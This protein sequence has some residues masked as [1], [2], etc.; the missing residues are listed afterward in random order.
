MFFAIGIARAEDN[1]SDAIDPSVHYQTVDHFTAS[2]CWSI[3][4]IGGWSDANRKK[5]AD[6]LFS[7]DKG[8]GLS[9]WRCNLG[10]GLDNAKI[11]SSW[12]RADTYEV[13][14]G[15]YDWTRC[16]NQR[17]FLAAAKARGVRE[18]IAF[19]NSPPERLT[20][21][22][23]TC[24]DANPKITNN[25]KPGMEH[26][27]G[28]YLADI[29]AHFRDNPDPAERINFTWVSPINE[30][31][32]DWIGG[33]EGSRASN[34][35]IRRQ[36]AAIFAELQRQHLSTHILGPE[37]GNIPDM[38]TR[39]GASDKYHAAFGDYVD[40]LCGDPALVSAMDHTIGY[41]SYWSDDKLHILY[42]RQV[43]RKKLDQFPQWRV[44]ETEYCVMEPGRNLGM[45]TAIRAMRIVEA[46]LT[47]ANAS[48]WA[49]WL[50][51]S[52]GDYKDGLLYTDWHRPGDEENVLTSK[53]FWAYGNFTR[54]V[55]P[56]MVRIAM[57]DT[58]AK[59]DINGLMSSAWRDPVN[60]KIVVVYIN[61]GD[62]PAVVDLKVSGG[63]S[64]KWTPF[65]TSDKPGDDLREY[66]A[67]AAGKAIHI[68]AT[69]VVTLVS[70]P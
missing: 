37:S 10:G 6:L 63:Q 8:I 70:Q 47:I 54:F 36:Y 12:R 45:A 9:A 35:D 40:T 11:R 32:W 61:A 41:H 7:R 48:G 29:L 58:A 33:Q 14:E 2:D 52:N 20:V 30:P 65:V 31:Q 13:A 53:L 43:L 1:Y 4:K 27:F 3:Q 66:P 38:S 18:F 39:G 23:L 17:W 21:N 57:H 26:Q 42:N 49:W 60:G 59:H 56:G 22:G 46:D 25:L 68:A 51:I 64:V 19:C 55:R 34:D 44:F 16:P 15:K 62:Q 69:S 67:I 5:V 50:A 24:T 28:R